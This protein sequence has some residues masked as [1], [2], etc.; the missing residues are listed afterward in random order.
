MHNI[1][2]PEVQEYTDTWEQ[3]EMFGMWEIVIVGWI[4]GLVNKV[5]NK[6][7]VGADSKERQRWE[8]NRKQWE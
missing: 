5:D 6:Q 4:A 1:F 8:Y 3:V 2:I 7:R